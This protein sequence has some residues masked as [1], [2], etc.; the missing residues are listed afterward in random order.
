M[1]LAVGALLL[2]VGLVL[3]L[4]GRNA[5]TVRLA[6]EFVDFGNSRCTIVN[7]TTIAAHDIPNSFAAVAGVFVPLAGRKKNR[8]TRWAAVPYRETR[9]FGD[10]DSAIH[11]AFGF[12]AINQ[13]VVCGVPPEFEIW[14]TRLLAFRGIDHVPLLPPHDER[15]LPIV[16][17]FDRATND[18]TLASFQAMTIGGGV[19]IFAGLL[20]AT[21]SMLV[22]IDCFDFDRWL[23]LTS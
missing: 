7:V 4:L 12:S 18:A 20:L 13:S 16:V 8:N 5:P 11:D 3:V 1:L 15:A 10:R 14:G 22:A 19:T 21:L 17:N 23:H 9:F 2:L 6:T